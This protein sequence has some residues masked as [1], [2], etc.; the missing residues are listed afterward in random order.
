MI[1]R[2]VK[3][4]DVSLERAYTTARWTF[5]LDKDGN[6]IYK[7]TDVK[8]KNDSNTVIEFLQTMKEW[9]NLE[10]KT[11]ASANSLLSNT[12]NPLIKTTME[13]IKNDSEKHK[14]ILQMI[15]D[16][17]TKE[18]LRL[19]PEEIAPLSDMLSRHIQTEAQ[20][21]EIA[22]KALEMGRLF[23]TRYFLSYILADE[24]KHHAMLSRLDEVK[25][26]AVFVT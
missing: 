21:I 16:N 1:T 26:A 2:S 17:L 5:V 7:D 22:K 11:I 14:T 12:N 4:V 8:A 23:V 19:T 6:V 10:D 13:M 25:K 9:Q 3:G 18:S 20:S 15:I 24:Q